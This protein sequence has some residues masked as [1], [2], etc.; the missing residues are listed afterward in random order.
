MANEKL[1]GKRVLAGAWGTLRI[2]NQDIAEVTAV[3]VDIAF[4]R[5]DIQWGLGKKSKITSVTGE[6]SLTV[7]KVY[8]RFI[9]QFKAIQEGKDVTFDLYL[10]EAD[11]DSVGGQ[12]ET[13]TINGAWLNDFKLGFEKASKGEREYSFGF[14]VMESKFSDII[15]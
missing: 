9:E 11:P 10:K 12:I 7:D 15:K 5:E 3:S 14:D 6:G 8:T 13:F 4:D 1:D 2:D